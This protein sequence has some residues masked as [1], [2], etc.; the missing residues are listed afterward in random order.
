[1]ELLQILWYF[2]FL[3]VWMGYAVLDGFDLGT[4]ALH[5]FARKDIDRRI[6]LNAIG[7]V[8][9]GNEVW[10]VI[11]MGALFAGFPYAYATLLSAYYVPIMVLIAGLILRAVAIEFRS[12]R[13]SPLWRS[14]WDL[15]FSLGSIVITLGLGIV[16][17]NLIEGINLDEAHVFHGSFK[18]FLSPYSLLVAVMLLSNFMMHGAIFLLMKTEGELHTR[19]RSWALRA[20]IFFV[21]MYVI[22]TVTTLLYQPHMIQ[23]FRDHPW[24]F[25]IAVAN[26]L[27][28]ANIVRQIRR[29]N[30]G[31]AFISSCAAMMLLVI[32]F[33]IGTYPTLVRAKNHPLELSLTIFN[34]SASLKTLQVLLIIVAI[35]IPLALAYIV[36]VY[37]VFRGKV[38]IDPHSY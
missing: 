6:F 28:I 36:S 29:R 27:A 4:G 11:L 3:I 21:I 33:A 23:P 10:L 38:K 26:G 24:I 12:K 16:L 20:M 30:D 2:V 31:W 13:A 5:L 7:P 8:W 9:D 34:A 15:V 17:G 32:L 14:W 19:L 18:D 25:L 37:Y 22:T 35:G 1:M